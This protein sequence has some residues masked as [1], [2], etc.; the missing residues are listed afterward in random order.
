[1]TENRNE[2][3]VD[4]SVLILITISHGLPSL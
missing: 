4:N 3:T 1:M 2:I